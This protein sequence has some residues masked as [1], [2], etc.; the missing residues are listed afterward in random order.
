M[1]YFLEYLPRLNTTSI[2]V[3]IPRDEIKEF[4]IYNDSI[5][6]NNIKIK[7]SNT[8]NH[9]Q[10][11]FT[12]N[13]SGK[14]STI[15]LK[16]ENPK[17]LSTRNS[18]TENVIQ[19]QYQ[20]NIKSLKKMKLLK[21]NLF[22]CNNCCNE[23]LN[24]SNIESL[25]PMPSELW[26]EMLDFWHCHK[27][28]PE[29]IKNSDLSLLNKFNQLKPNK[30]TI[31]IGSYY[32]L[33]NELDIPNINEINNKDLKCNRCNNIIGEIDSNY[34]C[35]KL[36]KWK[37][38]FNNEISSDF[39]FNPYSYVLS[40]LIEEMN[41]TAVKIFNIILNDDTNN[42]IKIWCFGLGINISIDGLNFNNCLKIMYKI[43]PK[44]DT[45]STNNTIEIEYKEPFD[46]FLRI[47]KE[48]NELLPE[49]LQIF[50]DWNISYIPL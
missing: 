3:N 45:D 20:W 34:S 16:D 15:R 46:D 29:D 47:I 36:F 41:Y 14:I 49:N 33:V 38:K 6:V 22:V 23:I 31:I 25:L 5:L 28:N 39:K 10:T 44:N 48:M 4:E 30:S 12:I 19:D 37:L 9:N 18:N 21:N 35:L 50:N 26:Y 13:E 2:Q 43:S 24:L 32:F 1:S 7:L 8:I 40:K 11:S 27:P 42:V 17:L